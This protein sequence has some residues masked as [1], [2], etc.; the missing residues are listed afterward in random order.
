MLNLSAYTPS[1]E[2]H[3]DE[4][5]SPLMDY[6]T[7]PVIT[8]PAAEFIEPIEGALPVVEEAVILP[9]ALDPTPLQPLPETG[10][11]EEI[12]A[13]N[14]DAEVGQL[15]GAQV[16]LEG[17]SKLLRSAGKNMTRQSAAFMAIGMSRANRIMGVTSLGLEDEDSGTQVMAMRQAKVDEKGLGTKIK[18]I[19]AKIWEWIK[20]KGRQLRALY[21]KIKASFTKSKEQVVYLIA[22]AEAVQSGNP[23]KVEKLEAPSGLK[24]SQVLD[25][26]HG[27]GVRNPPS[28]SVT[29]P[30]ALAQ[31]VTLDGKLDLNVKLEHDLRSGG[32]MAYIKDGTAFL[33]E[34][35][36]Y[37]GTITK[38]TSVEEISDN[39]SDIMKKTIGKTQATFPLH[40]GMS[41]V[42]S[43]DGSFKIT[44]TPVTEA[45]E[46]QSPGMPELTSFLK[47][48]EAT[49]DADVQGG[50]TAGAAYAAA[51][52]KM[53]QV[54]DQVS[55]KIGA[56]HA[57][58][59]GSA[60]GKV[61]RGAAIED[62]IRE[63]SI[64]MDRARNGA[65]AAADFFIA[66]HLGGG[67]SISQED[68]IALP[69]NQTP[70]G[71]GLGARIAAGAKAAWA[72]IKAFFIRMWE[73]LRDAVKRAWERLFGTDKQTDIL[74]LANN[75]VPEAGQ[76]P[77]GPAPELPPGSGLKSVAAIRALP[78]PGSPPVVET[79]PE[80]T[81]PE[82]RHEQVM[83]MPPQAP[84]GHVFAN[85]A[86]ILQMDST[87]AYDPTI[88]ET[89]VTWLATSYNP[90]LIKMWRDLISFVNS[91]IDP[92]E[93]DQWGKVV[94]DMFTRLMQGA[95]TGKF[96]G[97]VDVSVAPRAPCFSFS[98][99]EAGDEMA[100]VKIIGRRQIDQALSRQ[101]KSLKV[102]IS[103]EGIFAEHG[104][105]RNQFEA[106]IDRLINASDDATADQWA[107]LYTTVNRAMGT[108]AFNQLLLR[109]KGTFSARVELFDAMIVA[110]AKGKK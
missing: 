76:A 103:A 96:P 16:A 12:I 71:P 56:E 55:A 85:G 42:R 5:P 75:Y 91:G 25:A 95:P 39:V 36:T 73:Q 61:L 109:I 40:G 34:I 22:A 44:G 101:K 69:S 26:I 79:E 72:K 65:V 104:K 24:T 43:T 58:K 3:E 92:K 47:S 13:E 37:F 110:R 21:D 106:T 82:V 87:W 59:L 88:E 83:Q 32:V 108:T 70:S 9:P 29:L 81:A 52:E 62:N 2:N 6:N 98:R 50:E 105:L 84:A 49:L 90:G 8:P 89:Y 78:A 63:L 45:I 28:K 64:Y 57:D 66:S 1:V 15:M 93:T 51:L 35:A 94:T 46:V 54:G 18:E 10:M 4:I 30:G 19:A 107:A 100:P 97:N 27:E 41:A 53:M 14:L 68:Y 17:Y 99:G 86:K 102:L 74:L 80:V 31:Y 38:D 48:I 77:S 60:L 11:Q 7:T 23:A 67:N 20:E 33:N